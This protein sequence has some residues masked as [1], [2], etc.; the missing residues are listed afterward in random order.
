MFET[1]LK[2][3]LSFSR[4]EIDYEIIL[5]TNEIKSLLLILTR[6]KKQYIVKKYLDEMLRR[7]WIR[8]SKSLIT[9]SLF[10]IFKLEIKEKRLIIDYRKLNKKTVTDSTSLSLIKNI[11]NQIKK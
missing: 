6:S 5:K 11:M 10:L 3:E 9:T 8:V 4:K 1:I 7:N 2:R